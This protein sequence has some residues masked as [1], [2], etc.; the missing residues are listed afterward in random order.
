M[1][2]MGESVNAFA[3]VLHDAPD[4]DAGFRMHRMACLLTV[5]P[6][7]PTAVPCRTLALLGGMASSHR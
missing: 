5:A 1:R 3:A 6:R 2:N 7:D 4:D